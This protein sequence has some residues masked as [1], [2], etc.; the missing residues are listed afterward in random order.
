MLIDNS[1]R[2]AYYSKAVL[3]TLPHLFWV[4]DIFVCNGWQSAFVSNYYKNEYEG[5]SDFY[6]NIKSILI[7]HDYDEFSKV[8]RKELVEMDIKINP[9]IK[10]N[11]LNIYDVASYDADAILI[12]DRPG[13]KISSKLLKKTSFK[14]NQKKVK[15]FEQ[16]DLH[17]IDFY[18]ITESLESDCVRYYL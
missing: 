10:G 1:M 11:K 14:D 2:Y 15:V 3:S 6:K 12:M 13:E 16:K 4:P 9:N 5:T 7:V 18:A 17:D 8:D